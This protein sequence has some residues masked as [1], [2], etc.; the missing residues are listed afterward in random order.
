VPSKHTLKLWC[1]CSVGAD[2]AKHWSA[3]ISI[4]LVCVRMHLRPIW[5][6]SRQLSWFGFRGREKH[7]LLWLHAN[8]LLARFRSAEAICF[9]FNKIR[10]ENHLFATGPQPNTT[11]VWIPETVS[12]TRSLC[13]VSLHTFTKKFLKRGA[14]SLTDSN[15]EFLECAVGLQS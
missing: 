5:S 8:A 12:C 1:V 3:K 4:I 2:K 14:E 11:R 10:S 15:S 9:T 6:I 13:T 7:S